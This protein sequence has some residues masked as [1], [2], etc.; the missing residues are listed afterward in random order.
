[1]WYCNEIYTSKKFRER[2]NQEIL[3]I[4]IDIVCDTKMNDHMNDRLICSNVSFISH[5]S[6]HIGCIE[7]VH[8]NNK[9]ITH[10]VNSYC[11][12]VPFNIG[13]VIMFNN[14]DGYL[15][16]R[17]SPNYVRYIIIKSRKMKYKNKIIKISQGVEYYRI[18][19]NP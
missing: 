9:T 7:T 12:E 17:I 14:I 15:Y 1:M 13:Y 19:K 6:L 5:V 4:Q 2:R 10:F 18:L 3:N 16:A 8:I 11:K